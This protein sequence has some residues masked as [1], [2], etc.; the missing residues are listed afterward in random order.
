MQTCMLC[1]VEDSCAIPVQSTVDKCIIMEVQ[2]KQ[3]Y[4]FVSTLPNCSEL[5]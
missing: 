3:D 4:V 1:S 2:S 5:E